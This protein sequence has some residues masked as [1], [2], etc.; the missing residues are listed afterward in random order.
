MKLSQNDQR[1]KGCKDSGDTLGQ[2]GANDK[3]E[4]KWFYVS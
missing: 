4:N 1:D 2:S 3:K